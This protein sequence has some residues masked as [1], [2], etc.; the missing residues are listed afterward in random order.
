MTKAVNSLGTQSPAYDSLCVFHLI[1][2]AV[3]SLGTQSPVYNSFSNSH[4]T[5][6]L[7]LEG[8]VRFTSF[9]TCLRAR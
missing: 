6:E 3:N 8:F 9:G 5:I 7:N 2:K 4:S 1:T